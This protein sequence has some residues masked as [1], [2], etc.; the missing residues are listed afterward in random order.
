LE[1]LVRAKKVEAIIIV[2]PPRTLADLRAA[3]P[4]T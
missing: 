1:E 2:A 3:R 4:R